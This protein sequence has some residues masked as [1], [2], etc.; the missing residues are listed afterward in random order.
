[1]YDFKPL[2]SLSTIFYIIGICIAV[3]SII[4]GISI[5][6]S[7][8]YAMIIGVLAILGGVAIGISFLIV[9]YL[10]NLFLQIEE[11]TRKRL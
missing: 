6:V 5:I 8:L 9:Y 7:D 4:C 1:M 3:L 2:K 11:N 10:I